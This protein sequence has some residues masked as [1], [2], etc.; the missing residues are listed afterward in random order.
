MVRERGGEPR[1]IS[2]NKKQ[3]IMIFYT[4]DTPTCD[5]LI[6]RK[7]MLK[8]VCDKQSEPKIAA[9]NYQKEIDRQTNNMLE[10]AD[11][12]NR[13]YSNH[14]NFIFCSSKN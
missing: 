14:F 9:E 10:L 6:S 1:S 12:F 7:E 2:S 11:P 8:I 3:T 5:M 13:L 4:V